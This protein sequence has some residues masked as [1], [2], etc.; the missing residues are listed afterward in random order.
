LNFEMAAMWSGICVPDDWIEC[1][2]SLSN[3]VSFLH[4]YWTA[5]GNIARHGSLFIRLLP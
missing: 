5:A 2:A 3:H 4:E 1:A